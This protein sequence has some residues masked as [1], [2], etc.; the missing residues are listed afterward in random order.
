M[1]W[2]KSGLRAVPGKEDWRFHTIKWKVMETAI[3]VRI[4]II[5][6]LDLERTVLVNDL[7]FRKVKEAVVGDDATLTWVIR[8]SWLL[9]QRSKAVAGQL[10][11]VEC[12]RRYPNCDPH[13]QPWLRE[14]WTSSRVLDWLSFGK[15][16]WP[17]LKKSHPLLAD[18]VFQ[19]SFR[20]KDGDCPGQIH[21]LFLVG[22]HL[23]ILLVIVLNLAI[24]RKTTTALPA[25]IHRWMTSP[26]NVNS[27]FLHKTQLCNKCCKNSSTQKSFLCN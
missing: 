3:K 18:G 6:F 21:H 8:F 2:D 11:P 16:S 22:H 20:R 9:L 13:T 7:S 14:E 17:L 26:K 23:G 24:V 25:V 1:P 5:S 19:Y 27:R 4:T 10:R 15:I 12:R